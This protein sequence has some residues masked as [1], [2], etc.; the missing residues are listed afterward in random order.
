ME[1]VNHQYKDSVFSLLFSNPEN[2]RELYCALKGVTLP[3]NVPIVVNTL[4]N[5]LF[6]GINNDVS[7]LI[8]GKL[9]VLVEHQSSINQNMALRLLQYICEVY[10]SLIPNDALHSSKLVRVPQ[11][12]FYVLYN[13]T[14]A[15]PDEEVMRLSAAFEDTRT[16]GLATP[17]EPALELVVRILNINAGRNAEIVS[18]CRSLAEYSAFV[19]KFRALEK[20]QYSRENAMINTV[21]YCLEHGI[22]TQFLMSHAG[23]VTGMNIFEWRLEDAL[24]VE[25]K[26][27][28]EDGLAQGQLQIARNALAKNMPPELIRD[29]TGLDLETIKSLQAKPMEQA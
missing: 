20:I 28:M 4:E 27:G 8:G 12:E 15:Y 26:E 25:R 1:E 16:L 23:E 22:L 3:P 21:R 29:I 5:V 24:A 6:R 10:K 2:L 11:P 17:A 14:A 13:G 7:F 18:R 19:A 9:V